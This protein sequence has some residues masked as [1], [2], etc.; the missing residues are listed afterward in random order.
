MERENLRVERPNHGM[1]PGGETSY[2]RY[3]LNVQTVSN[4]TSHDN[5]SW[6]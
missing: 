3:S 6:G 1:E 5:P 4:Q 2:V